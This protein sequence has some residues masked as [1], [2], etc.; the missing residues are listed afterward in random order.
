[1][2]IV[3]CIC[4]F[5]RP[6][7]LAA[8]LSGV[9]HLA[10]RTLDRPKLHVI[11]VDNEGSDATHAVVDAFA[12]PG[13]S[14]T[15]AV[16]SRRG[17]SSARNACLD[18]IPEGADLV[19]FLDDDVVPRRAWLEELVI[20]VEQTGAEAATGPCFAIY[21][22]NT[23]E[24]IRA[25]GIFASPRAKAPRNHEQ[26]DF[27]VMGNIL[28]RAPFLR[29]NGLRFDER[30]GLIGGE[31]RKFF[32]DMFDVGGTFVWA[33]NA[34]VDHH[35]APNRLRFGYIIRREFGVGF[36]AAILK[37]SNPR[38]GGRALGYGAAVVGRLVLKIVLLVPAAL[39]G[40]LRDKPF[41]K[42]KPV[43]DIANLSGRLYGLFGMKYELYR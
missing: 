15:Y 23:P 27:G 34:V 21:G 32:T 24:W 43:L 18:L 30:F 25:G 17:I 16:E 13:I 10:F 11:V 33:G 37:R 29:D 5:R 26:I 4:T 22:G 6:E 42:V 31:D 12:V 8:T 9:E 38:D 40:V 7:G 39:L 20:A 35:V 36:A 41:R 2:L 3:I 14:I 19:A 1:M 28:L